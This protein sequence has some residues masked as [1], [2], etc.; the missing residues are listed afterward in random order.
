MDK[1]KSKEIVEGIRKAVGKTEYDCAGER[2]VGDTGSDDTLERYLGA[3]A[4]VGKVKGGR[5]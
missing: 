3:D 2:T 4:S 5:E 1:D